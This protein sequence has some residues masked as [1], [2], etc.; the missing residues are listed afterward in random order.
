MLKPIQR[1][2]LEMAI[3]GEDEIGALAQRLFYSIERQICRIFSAC[4]P[5]LLASFSWSG[6]ATLMKLAL[7]TSVT[8]LTPSCCSLARD[9]WLSSIAS[10][11]SFAPTSVAAACTQPFC[12]S[13]SDAHSLSLTQITLLLASCSVIDRTGATS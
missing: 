5:R 8:T 12:S 4:G 3:G 11:G 1:A 6:S 7:S 9:L 10:A 2:P 13:L